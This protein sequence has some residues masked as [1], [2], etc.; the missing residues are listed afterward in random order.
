MHHSILIHSCYTLSA[1]TPSQAQ[2]RHFV[3]WVKINAVHSTIF[4]VTLNI[5]Q[6][7]LLLDGFSLNPIHTALWFGC[8][9][10][11][12]TFLVLGWQGREDGFVIQHRNNSNSAFIFKFDTSNPQHFLNKGVSFHSFWN[13]TTF[14]N[15]GGNSIDIRRVEKQSL[16]CSLQRGG[17]GHHVDLERFLKLL[18]CPWSTLISLSHTYC[19]RKSV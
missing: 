3:H 10:L 15:P 16:E 8:S 19:P 18:K 5:F 13:L 17:R 4:R 9:L 12:F 2:R 11:P 1:L 7:L 6:M 14:L